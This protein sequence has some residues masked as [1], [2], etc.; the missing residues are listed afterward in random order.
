MEVAC[1]PGKHSLMLATSFLKN[2]GVL[3]SCDYSG[4]MVNRLLENYSQVE[5]ENEYARVEG[6][7]Y[8]IEQKTDFSEFSDQTGTT[9][10]NTCDIETVIKE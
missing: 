3:V 9:L 4:G 6:N 2:K 1:G 5:E 10:K 8:V 7:K